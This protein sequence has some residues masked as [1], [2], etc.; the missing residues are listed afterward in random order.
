MWLV[1]TASPYQSGL[2][3]WPYLPSQTEKKNVALDV[4]FAT[5]IKRVILYC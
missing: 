3:A 2:L 1:C 4:E 5:Q